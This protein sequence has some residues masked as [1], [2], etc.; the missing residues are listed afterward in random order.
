MPILSAQDMLPTVFEPI[1][2]HRFVLYYRDIPTYMIKS[3]DG[4]GWDDGSVTIDYINAYTSF[5]A[6]RRY[7]DINLSLYDPVSPSGAQALESLGLLQYELLSGRSAYFD[8]YAT[9]FSLQVLGPSGDIVRE[10][11][12][13]KAFIMNAKYGTYDY[14]TE[15]YTTIDIT[16]KHSGLVLNY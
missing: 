15:V 4:L 6:K 12:I 10:W 11:I 7:S 9:D 5:R 2:S 14:S 16:I 1:L 8:V 3:I 13:K